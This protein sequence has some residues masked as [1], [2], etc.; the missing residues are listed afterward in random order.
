MKLSKVNIERLG[1]RQNLFLN[2]LSDRLTVVVDAQ[3][4][5]NDIARFLSGTFFG[6]NPAQVDRNYSATAEPAG[7]IEVNVGGQ[8]YR[9]LRPALDPHQS[10]LTTPLDSATRSPGLGLPR[11]IDQETFET[12]FCWDSLR[13][14]SLSS[15]ES[16]LL[17]KFDCETRPEVRVGTSGV[18]DRPS[19]EPHR[20]NELR[21][22]HEEHPAAQVRLSRELATT[23]QPSQTNCHLTQEQ[24]VDLSAK[25]DQCNSRIRAANSR[26]DLLDQQIFEL[27]HLPNTTLP[28]A[29]SAPQFVLAEEVTLLYERLDE[30]D[31]QWRLWRDVQQVIQK[32]RVQIRDE[33]ASTA[34]LSLDSTEHPFHDSRE[35]I[36]G[37]GEKL[38]EAEALAK[39]TRDAAFT[40][41]ALSIPWCSEMRLRLDVLCHELG[42]QFRQVRHRT[43]A[44]E[45]KQ[46]RNCYND[47]EESVK[48][49]MQRRHSI[50]EQ[51]HGFDP[52]GAELV[53]R[54]NQQFC[55]LAQQEGYH[56]ARRRFASQTIPFTQTVA[57]QTH[58]ESDQWQLESMQQQRN[59]V[60]VENIRAE[61]ELRRLVSERDIVIDRNNRL[62]GNERGLR[63]QLEQ[64]ESDLGHESAEYDSI[65]EL[66]ID[67][68]RHANASLSRIFQRA[69]QSLSKLTGGQWIGLNSTEHA[70]GFAATNGSGLSTKAELLDRRT[71]NQVAFSLCLAVI[72][73]F[74]ERGESLPFVLTGV[75]NIAAGIGNAAL[76]S[77][78]DECLSAGQQIIASV[79][80]AV[81]A[82]VFAALRPVVIEL[83]EAKSTALAW[84]GS[85]T[86]ADSHTF[87]EPIA[88]TI[89]QSWIAPA[90]SRY[91]A[92]RARES[93][94][95]PLYQFP[96]NRSPY[97]ERSRNTETSAKAETSALGS[98]FTLS[99]LIRDTGACVPM[100]IA[101]LDRC[102]IR[103]IDELLDLDAE[104]MSR[105]LAEPHITPSQIRR[106]QACCWL[107]ICVPDMAIGDAQV[108][109]E[110]GIK[111]P[112]QLE[113]V[114]GEMLLRKLGEHLS[115]T[116][117][118][119]A[120]SRYNVERI[121]SWMRS[122]ARTRPTWKQL[123]RY[124]IQPTL[125]AAENTTTAIDYPKPRTEESS[126]EAMRYHLNLNDAVDAAPSIGAK[127]YQQLVQIGVRTI[128]DFLNRTSDDISRHLDNRRL[129]GDTIAQW[130]QQARI[131]CSIP[132]LRRHDAQILVACGVTEPQK[133]AA[134]NANE[135]FDMVNRFVRS[136]AGM[137]MLRSGKKPD[138]AEV[139]DW[140][141]W[142]QHTRSLQAA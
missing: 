57:P 83:P 1:L 2:R 66:P 10:L 140:I 62:L 39:A 120:I 99:S 88:K 119:A 18:V 109:V 5:A 59:D 79:C 14:R 78:L 28:I 13:P 137:R 115:A 75:Q 38:A 97:V 138:L 26:R 32:R 25:I 94:A 71:Q 87:R 3:A 126:R 60:H 135:L 84:G 50:I 40:K 118:S 37:L 49:L 90:F 44:A 48:R 116:G 12:F 19:I 15:M 113:E 52:E 141:R 93:S 4:D 72:S 8:S 22:R 51:I 30:I 80:R 111:S 33:L 95:E 16:L 131:A 43:A 139:T 68:P 81:D 91:Q 23:S 127:V 122:L 36:R 103:T 53:L 35:I 86:L 54:G 46:L 110:C 89:S 58:R 34:E 104:S 82:N 17:R 114:R 20:R 106:W 61:A 124:Q 70:V 11:N 112:E 41:G 136:K 102:R 6:I 42:Q 107:L 125:A 129:S 21:R 85:L 77:L 69:G 108:L 101:V 100:E 132:N 98:G 142:A 63:R 56:R 130:Q 73:H 9:V 24:L 74:R 128:H 55:A 123:N 105:T 96:I 31:C 134:M 29:P 117:R 45:L 133:L 92:E 65:R 64:I 76:T 27:E 121:N 67:P 47:L 7:W